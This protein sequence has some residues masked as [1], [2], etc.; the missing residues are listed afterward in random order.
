MAGG[1]YELWETSSRNLIGTFSTEKDALKA[2]LQAS[3][4]NGEKYARTWLLALEDES[5]ETSSIAAG[6]ELIKRAKQ[7]GV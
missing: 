7:S 6:S 3:A 4:A 1:V 2:V 5:G